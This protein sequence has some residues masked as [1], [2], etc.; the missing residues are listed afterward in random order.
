[1]ENPNLQVIIVVTHAYTLHVFLVI[2]CGTVLACSTYFAMDL[3]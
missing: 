3:L 1:M 2:P